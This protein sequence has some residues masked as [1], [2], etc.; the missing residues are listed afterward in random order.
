MEVVFRLKKNPKPSDFINE[1]SF[2]NSRLVL[3]RGPHVAFATSP[4]TIISP[5]ASDVSLEVAASL[6]GCPSVLV[7]SDLSFYSPTLLIILL[8]NSTYLLPYL[9]IYLLFLYAN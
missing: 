6:T 7:S 5:P 2:K 4:L 1:A 9:F 8:P 3:V